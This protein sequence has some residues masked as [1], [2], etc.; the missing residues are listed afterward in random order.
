MLD[1]ETV[2]RVLAAHPCRKIPLG[3]MREAA[4]LV[5]LLVRDGSDHLL[6]TRRTDHLP[7]HQGEIS[8]P[9]GARN[10]ED[11]DLIATALRETEEEMGIRPEDVTVLGR[12]DDFHSVHNYHVVPHVGTFP[13]PYSLQANAREIAEVIIL[14]L[15]AF[16]DPAVHRQEDW[17]H[18]GRSCPVDFYTVGGYVI[19]GLTAAIL[20]QFMQRI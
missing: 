16:A 5:P 6:F 11:P 13:W 4:V 20:R 17:R 14:P 7:H 10:R 18:R 1:P 2:R 8:F 9:G 12:L 15:D 19:W 3:A